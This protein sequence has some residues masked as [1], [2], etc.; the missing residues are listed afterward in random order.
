[1]PVSSQDAR[2][3]GWACAGLSLLI[4]IIRATAS[5]LHYGTLDISAVIVIAAIV[6]VSARIV[7]NQYVLSYGTSNDAI[8]GKSQY[9]NSDDT[10]TLKSGSILALI[11]RLLITTFYWLQNCLLL[12]FY[13]RILEVRA[14]W[15]TR[16]IQLCWITIPLTY[17]AV[18]LATFLECHPFKL[19]WQIQPRPGSCIR[20]YDQLL[21][22]GIA[23]ILLDLILLAI[24]WP[25]VVVR[26]RSIGEKLRVGALFCL[27]FFCIITTCVR[28]GYIYAEQSYQPVRSFWA[29]VQ[30]VV[31]C[32]VANAP[33]IY[34]CL[35]L[36]RRRKSQRAA[37][38]GS[39]PELWLHLKITNETV[40]P[41]NVPVTT[42]QPAK[43]SSCSEK[44]WSQWVP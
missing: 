36:I 4:L 13:S 40:A 2:I 31:S 29:S 28:I 5:R 33:T 39:R 41:A 22:Q 9:F 14:R 32:F 37:R 34:G 1:M 15:T 8:Y 35:K 27:G 30:M 18:V 44:G 24:A 3:A 6:V 19:Y 11:A 43:P 26:H 38:R 12:L 17:I 10:E 21:T 7:V 42:D 23:N 16:L 20:A 25:L